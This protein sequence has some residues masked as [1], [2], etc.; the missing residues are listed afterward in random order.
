[1]EDCKHFHP[2]AIAAN[3][4]LDDTSEFSRHLAS[5]GDEGLRREVAACILIDSHISSVKY[6]RVT[7]SIRL[8]GISAIT[9]L[10]Y[11]VLIQF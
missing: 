7:T 4:G 1:M 6:Q 8:M 2:A 9:G 5:I 3:F 10:T 11:L